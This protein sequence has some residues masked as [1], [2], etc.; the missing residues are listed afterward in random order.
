MFI[1][2]AEELELG[3]SK[4]GSL[5]QVVYPSYTPTGRF[6]GMYHPFSILVRGFLISYWLSWS[7]GWLPS[8]IASFLGS[9]FLGSFLPCLHLLVLYLQH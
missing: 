9:C 5:L 4:G 6:P 8:E 7:L 2:C 3:V 1:G